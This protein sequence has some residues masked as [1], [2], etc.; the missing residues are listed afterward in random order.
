MKFTNKNDF[1]EEDYAINAE[2]CLGFRK[3]SMPPI[4]LDLR[5]QND[6][7]KEHLIGA[8]SIPAEFLQDNLRKIPPYAKVILYSDDD[9][10]SIKSAQLLWENK[11]NNI[12]YVTGGLKSLMETLR[13]SGNEI[14][15]ADLPEDQC[16]GKIEEVLNEKVRPALAADGGGL[17]I[18]KIEGASVYIHYQGACA[19]CASST[20]GTLN[21]IKSAL[22]VSLNYEI[23]VIAS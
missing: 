13:A 17:E 16:K 21:F 19:G 12:S 18:N 7:Q 10:K 11:Y 9:Q 15:L 4:I 2:S 14:F 3:S 5:S 20:T 22:S 23:E 8:H 1:K 6:Y